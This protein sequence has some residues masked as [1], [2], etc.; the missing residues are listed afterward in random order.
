MG[1]AVEGKMEDAKVFFYKLVARTALLIINIFIV[2]ATVMI[3][4]EYITIIIIIVV[5][6]SSHDKISIHM[7][8]SG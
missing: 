4:Y 1:L 5:V 7:N 3:K 8:R 2:V 6:V